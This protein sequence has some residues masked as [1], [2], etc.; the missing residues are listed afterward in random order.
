MLFWLIGIDRQVR[1]QGVRTATT[2]A[3]KRLKPARREGAQKDFS[4]HTE[5]TEKYRS[6]AYTL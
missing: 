4:L 2:A 6:D 1:G 5:L 3:K